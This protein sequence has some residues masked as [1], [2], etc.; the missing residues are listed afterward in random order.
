MQRV[1][2]ALDRIWHE[3]R[4]N[5][6][7]ETQRRER[8]QLV[9]MEALD[10]ESDAAAAKQEIQ[11]FPKRLE[12][13]DVGERAVVDAGVFS[14]NRLAAKLQA[15]HRRQHLAPLRRREGRT[16][17]I[18]KPAQPADSREILGRDIAG[19]KRRERRVAKRRV[20]IMGQVH[21]TNAVDGLRPSLAPTKVGRVPGITGD[22]DE[23]LQAADRVG[24]GQSAAIHGEKEG[25]RKWLRIGPAAM[26]PWLY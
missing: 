6:G 2:P 15:A 18:V 22:C 5:G 25:V 11:R 4:R 9:N 1:R 16:N 7:V 23:V 26:R 13:V 24:N 20:A 10:G 17:H 21:V 3:E 8:G 12:P 19:R 14:E